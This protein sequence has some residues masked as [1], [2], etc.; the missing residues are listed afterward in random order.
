MLYAKWLNHSAH[1]SDQ[2]EA[3]AAVDSGHTAAKPM[4]AANADEF[5]FHLDKVCFSEFPV[6]EYALRG[7]CGINRVEAP[8]ELWL[9]ADGLRVPCLTGGDRPDVA[10]HFGRAKMR[11][12]GFAARV[13]VRDRRSRLEFFAAET[14]GESLFTLLDASIWEDP[15]TSAD[16]VYRNWLQREEKS[17]FW[18]PGKIVEGL[19]TLRYLPLISV[20]LPTFNTDVYHLHRCVTSLLSQKY[21]RWEVCISD[22]G[23]WDPR[24][25]SAL[26]KLPALD[27]RISVT[28]NS[29]NEGISAASN[30]SLKRAKGDFVVLL[31][32][33][34]ELHP[35]A[36]LEL[37]RQLNLTPDADLVYSDEDKIDQAGLRSHPAFKPGYDEDLLLAFNYI[38]H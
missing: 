28:F 6:Q 19:A 20:I 22:D 29:R 31:D 35:Y 18:A 25:L 7:W 11:K 9:E 24:T 37:V 27:Q 10:L 36:L 4:L 21:A 16:D 15:E 23:S 3:S 8:S 33:D 5:V 14:G 13:P 2:S 32:H 34:D 1:F 30:G 38:G 17:L 26:G 12:C